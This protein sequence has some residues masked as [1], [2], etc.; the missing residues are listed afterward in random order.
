[1]ASKTNYS[2]GDNKYYRITKVVGH[3][4][5]KAG[6]E[7]PVR[8]EFYGTCKAD[9]ER[10]YNEYLENKARNI[11]NSK[12]YFGI[13]ADQ[14]LYEFLAHDEGVS[15]NTIK[16]Y[17]DTWNIYIKPLDLYHL[18]LNE[19]T[20]GYLQKVYNTL[21]KEGAPDSALMTIN[22]VMARFFKHLV[23]AGYV[24]FNYA[25]E[26]TVP[27]QKKEEEHK[28]IV[29]TDDELSAIMNGF[30][31]AQ[32]GFRLRFLIVLANYTGLRISELLGL[33]YE[34]IVKTDTGYELKVR[35][36]ATNL[37]TYNSDGTKVNELGIKSLKSQCSYRTI[38]LNSRVVDELKIHRAWHLAECVRNG[39]RT[40]FVFTTD[41][42][43]LCDRVNCEHAC[44]SYYK[45]IGVEYKGFHT[46]R[47]T[48]ATRLYKNG[49]KMKTASELLGHSSITVTAKYYV[50]TDDDEKRKAVDLLEAM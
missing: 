35:R 47:H 23:Q 48:F 12:Q 32:K 3:K 5:N 40:D 15:V 31:K 16:L 49:V 13:L 17:I 45:R 1:M 46:Y 37:T 27:Q 36:Q 19:I 11:D 34:D 20:V 22:K 21:K 6:N 50:G 28:I 38:P 14:W 9:A 25:K 4:I 18:P 33:K 39:Y 7:V 43:K 29:W 30:S 26:L 10:K 24:P 41:T 2:K 44:R 42:G 8:K